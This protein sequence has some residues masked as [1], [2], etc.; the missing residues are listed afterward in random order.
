MAERG[1]EGH[2]LYNNAYLIRAS[3]THGGA[4]AEYLA[5]KMFTP[6]W[7]SREALRPRWGDSLAEFHGRLVQQHGFGSFLAQQVVADVMYYF[8]LNDAPD[9]YSFCAPGPGSIQ[10]LNIIL[11]RSLKQ[12]FKGD[13]FKFEAGRLQ[14][15]VNTKLKFSPPLHRQDVTNALCEYAKY[16]KA[17][18]GVQNLKRKYRPHEEKNA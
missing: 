7:E 1:A 9:W 2:I 12:S 6:L 16:V 18:R 14:E 5:R 11:G 4:K 17:Q 13:E 8:P 10:G 15:T 3:A